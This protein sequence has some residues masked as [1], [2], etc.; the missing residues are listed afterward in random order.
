MNIFDVNQTDLVITKEAYL[1]YKEV[2]LS[3]HI[4]SDKDVIALIEDEQLKKIANAYIMVLTKDAY[5]RGYFSGRNTIKADFK[6][7]LE[8][9]ELDYF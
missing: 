2:C 3:N 6:K 5:E 9:E 1:Q 4:H 8:T 7:L